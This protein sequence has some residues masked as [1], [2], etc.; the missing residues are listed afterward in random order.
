MDTFSSSYSTRFRIHPLEVHGRP[1]GRLSSYPEAHP[2]ET[3]SGQEKADL[4]GAW[5]LG[6]EPTARV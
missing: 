2:L 5:S 6:L 3:P 4:L 1:A